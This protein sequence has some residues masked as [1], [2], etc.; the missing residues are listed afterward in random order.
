[1]N[2]I[3]QHEVTD[4][5]ESVTTQNKTIHREAEELD[6]E[7]S[8]DDFL[9]QIKNGFYTT[10]ITAGKATITAGKATIT[11]GKGMA[12]LATSLIPGGTGDESSGDDETDT[13]SLKPMGQTLAHTAGILSMFVDVNDEAIVHPALK[14]NSTGA[15]DNTTTSAEISSQLIKFPKDS[16][17]NNDKESV[18]PDLEEEKSVEHKGAISKG[19]FG[20]FIKTRKDI[21][22]N[23]NKEM[24]ET[25]MRVGQSEEAKD[26]TSAGFFSRLIKSSKDSKTNTDS[27]G[28]QPDLKD[29]NSLTEKKTSSNGFFS[30]L[31]K[32]S[33]HADNETNKVA[34]PDL[35]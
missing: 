24:V 18:K 1:M 28:A 10:T 6:K 13:S 23:D 30:T 11:A 33:K 7:L 14:E 32:S 21:G 29:E 26:T 22:D 35:T 15:K 5:S 2:A 4:F 16:G 34:E 12:S 8:E 31:I 20:S 3:L 19:F 17:N 9:S 27:E 25:D